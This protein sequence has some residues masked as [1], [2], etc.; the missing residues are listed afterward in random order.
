MCIALSSRTRA[1]VIRK[2]TLARDLQKNK[3]T[4]DVLLNFSSNTNANH[5]IG[6]FQS[7]T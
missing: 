4:L 3:V 1:M 6:Q 2:E 7:Q 5:H